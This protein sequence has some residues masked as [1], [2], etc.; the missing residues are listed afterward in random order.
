MRRTPRVALAALLLAGLAE[1][2]PAQR[3]GSTVKAAR[4]DLADM[5]G[6]T[7]L[8]ELI[9]YEPGSPRPEVRVTVTRIGPNQVRVSSDHARLPSFTARLGRAVDTLRNV[10]GE[11]AF[12]LDLSKSPRILAV[13]VDAV[14]WT[15]SKQ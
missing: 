2:A 11:G 10:G 1:P 4:V 14:F 6:G 12:L 15:G 9:P 5:A 8:G 7:Y 3:A 13:T